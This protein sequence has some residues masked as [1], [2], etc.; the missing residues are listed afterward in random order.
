MK[1]SDLFIGIDLGTSGIRGVALNEVGEVVAEKAEAW[2]QV[3]RDPRVWLGALD[4][5]FASLLDQVNPQSVRALSCCGTSGTVVAVDKEGDPLTEAWLY[6]DPRGQ[7]QA[8]RLGISGSWGLGRWLWW[9]ETD[10]EGYA[11]SWLA[12]P[13]DVMLHHLGGDPHLTDHTSALKSGFD[14]EKYDWPEGWL[15]EYGLDPERFPQVVSPGSLVGRHESGML[16]VAGCTDGCAGQLAAGA[17][18]VGQIS[19]SLGTTLIF[20]GVSSQRIHTPDG[21]VY[22]HLHPDR[23]AWL[24]G[25]ASYC[26][27]GILRHFFPQANLA[28]QDRLAEALIPTGTWCYPLAGVGER[29]PRMDP[30]FTGVLP[31]FERGSLAFY[32][33]LLEGVAFVEREGLEKLQALGLEQQGSLW[34]TGG[35]N[36]S[37]LWLRIRASVLNRPLAI[38]RY[39]QPAVGAAILAAAGYWQCSVVEAA[40]RLVQ[41]D[42]EIEPDPVWARRYQGVTGS[43]SS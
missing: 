16:L 38:S 2:P 1:R 28:Q 26:G 23:T 41:K 35:G 40:A 30:A 19:T 27:G 13:T 32:A 29:F 24:P 36:R 4:G 33:A 14:L 17:M 34:V 37:E 43:L 31:E 39:P 42:R 20:K 6:E 15:R 9:A 11:R 10:P 22:S 5:I 12:H 25:A 8:R 21:S 18:Q 7:E 3:A